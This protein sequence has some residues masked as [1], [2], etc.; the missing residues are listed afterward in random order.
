[1]FKKG[2]ASAKEELDIL[3]A[4]IPVELTLSVSAFK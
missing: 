4:P 1:M 2:A 3:A